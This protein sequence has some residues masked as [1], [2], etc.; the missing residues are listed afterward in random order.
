MDRLLEYY[1][2]KETSFR[3][4]GTEV[5]LF[6]SQALFS[7]FEIDR[8]SR[9]LLEVLAKDTDFTKTDTVLDL[10]CGVG[11][12]GISLKKRHPH[13]ELTFQD[14]DALATAF[15]E[16][17]W[18]HNGLHRTENFANP[19]ILGGLAFQGLK[20]RSFDL[21]ISNIPAKV[22]KSV[23]SDIYREMC[24]HLSP[25]GQVLIVVVEAI[26]SYTLTALRESG[27]DIHTVKPSKGHTVVGFSP[28]NSSDS[29][30]PP[31]LSGETLVLQAYFRDHILCE[32]GGRQYGL[33][34]VWGSA[35]FDTPPYTAL[36]AARLRERIG[37]FKRGLIW[38]PG[39]GHIAKMVLPEWSEEPVEDSTAE[40]PAKTA[41]AVMTSAAPMVLDLAG[42]D[43][44]DLLTCRHNLPTHSVP[45]T[46]G[47]APGLESKIFHCADPG[48]LKGRVKPGYDLFI[49][50]LENLAGVPSTISVQAAAEELVEEG[51]IFAVLGKSAHVKAFEGR[52]PGF[53][54][55]GAKKHHGYR[56]LFFRKNFKPGF[57]EAAG[58]KTNN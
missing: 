31:E 43:S 5:S 45:G 54:G 47:Q 35:G 11:T 40:P 30:G 17:N 41:I 50:V 1:S 16:I 37:S 53:S 4:D 20:G 48:E 51:G 49:A 56:T 14:R 32:V 15:T 39:Q 29:P 7:S 24:T 36:L 34:T 28:G 26:T 38:N 6:L 33:D 27:M 46:A 10:G 22:G 19:A 23:L 58:K 57:D 52:M 12:L 9:L 21:I 3:Y 55:F 42:R 13:L 18:R 25:E 2:N 44:L 8:G